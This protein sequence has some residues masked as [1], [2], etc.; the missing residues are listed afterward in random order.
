LTDLVLAHAGRVVRLTVCGLSVAVRDGLLRCFLG[1]GGA[2]GE[3]AADCMADGRT[4]CNATVLRD[5]C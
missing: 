2:A 1:R 4:Y 3:P 5:E